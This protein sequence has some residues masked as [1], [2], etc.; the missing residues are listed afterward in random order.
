M[1]IYKSQVKKISS[2]PLKLG[3][4]LVSLTSLNY[5]VI[6]EAASKGAIWIQQNNI[7]KILRIRSIEKVIQPKDFVWFYYDP[8]VLSLSEISSLELIFECKQY[9]V[10]IKPAGVLSQ[11]TQAGAHTSL[12]RYI[13]KSKNNE[14]YLV[15]RLD[16]ETFGL[17]IVAYNSLAA[18]T[19]CDLFQK[20]KI[21]KFYHAIVVGN[22]T[23]MHRSRID[24]P[25][26]NKSAVTEFEVLESVGS[27]SLLRLNLKTGRL[28]QIRRHLALQGTPVLGDPKYGIGNKNSSGLQLAATELNFYDPWAKESKMFKI[29]SPLKLSEF[30]K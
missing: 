10:W 30:L 18:A 16:R 23:P 5:S 7:G 4:F 15:H 25:L 20:N 8:K 1:K 21:E 22:L 17:M 27:Y 26:D 11:G 14:A 2:K 29:S 19:F 24:F 9:G 12:L 28:H 3:D 6:K 13:E